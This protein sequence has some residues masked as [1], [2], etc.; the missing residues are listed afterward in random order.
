MQSRLA[1]L[2]Q[3]GMALKLW[4]TRLEGIVSHES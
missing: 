4:Q 1:L 3:S 2:Q